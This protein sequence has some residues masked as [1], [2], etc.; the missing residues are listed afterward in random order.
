MADQ[1]IVCLDVLDVVPAEDDVAPSEVI[2]KDD[3]GGA[4][5]TITHPS[6]VDAQ[7]DIAV[8]QTCGHILHDACLKEW[9]QKANSCPICRQQFNL[10][11]V[12]KTTTGTSAM[13]SSSY[14]IVLGHLAN[15]HL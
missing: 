15:Y 10:V 1:C 12:H 2:A 3:L 11:E 9:T 4:T 8:I 5:A 7:Q 14:L 6:N 13:H